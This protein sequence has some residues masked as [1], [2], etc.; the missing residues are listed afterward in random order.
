MAFHFSLQ[1]VLRVRLAEHRRN[2]AAWQKSTVHVN[3]LES[4]IS[5]LEAQA[6]AL[7]TASAQAGTASELHFD[8]ALRTTLV[9][10]QA[11][12]RQTL[13]L[14][15]E[16]QAR[17]AAELR[18]SWQACEALNSMRQQEQDR[19]RREESRREQQ[20]QDDSFLAHRPDSLLPASARQKLPLGKLR[21]S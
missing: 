20:R 16:R 1:A 3:E 14:V 19:H 15:R 5:Q 13:A 9:Q 8:L 6:Q 2:E 7:S 18:R 17:E 10:S 11:A 12:L 21:P 4:Q